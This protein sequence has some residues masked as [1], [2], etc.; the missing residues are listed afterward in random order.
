MAQSEHLPIYKSRYDVCLYLEQVVQKFSR[1]HKYTLGAELTSREGAEPAQGGLLGAAV[2]GF[3]A[4]CANA[5]I[6]G[7]LRCRHTNARLE[8][9]FRVVLCR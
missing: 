1:Y 4:S 8:S 9:P 2:G 5:A 7:R 3:P 6:G